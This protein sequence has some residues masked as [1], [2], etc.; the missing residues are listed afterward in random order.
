VINNHDRVDDAA[1][2]AALYLSGAMDAHE[3]AAFEATL[4]GGREDYRAE[5]LRLQ[6]GVMALGQAARPVPPPPALRARILRQVESESN[7]ASTT[8]GGKDQVWRQWSSDPDR[9]ALFT[10]RAGDGA[11]EETGV[12]GVRVRRLFVDRDGNRMTAM[13][14]MD[15][16]AAYPEHL[17]DGPEE[18]YVLE[19]DLHVGDELVMH[20]GDYQRAT[21]RSEHGKQW[22]Q[23]GCLLLVTSSLSDEMV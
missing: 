2:L 17:H 3:R 10:L 15:P 7:A 4:Q 18:C 14:Q 5:L 16:G 19:G 11:W 1:E 21:P 12:A 23:G 6:E 20:K 22:T 13:F 9:D 8:A